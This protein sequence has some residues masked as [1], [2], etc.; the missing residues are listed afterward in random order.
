[1]NKITLAAAFMLLSVAAQ[2]KDAKPEIPIDQWLL[3]HSTS[4]PAEMD[5][6]AM[7][8]PVMSDGIVTISATLPVKIIDGQQILT[9]A[10]VA[11]NDNQELTLVSVEPEQGEFVYTVKQ[12]RGSYKDAATV[13]YNLN[14]VCEKGQIILTACNIAVN[15]KEKGIIPRTLKMEKFNPGKHQRH[16]ELID[17]TALEVSKL[18]AQLASS[19]E[20]E[21]AESVSHWKEILAG[22][23]VQGM[24][25][26]EVTLAK[27]KPFSVSGPASKTKWRYEDNMLVIFTDGIVS[28]VI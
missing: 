12:Q 11:N 20:S 3:T 14:G 10:L 7:H 18:M 8:Y 23:V 15:Y 24:N 27:G 17:L 16:A 1:M 25:M 9:N 4:A 13:S 2:A 22:N 28:R 5:G 26:T 21:K 6:V 19:A